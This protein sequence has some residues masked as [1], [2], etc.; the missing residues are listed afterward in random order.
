MRRTPASNAERKAIADQHPV[1]EPRETQ[2][3]VDEDSELVDLVSA[4]LV[5]PRLHTD[6]RM[7]LCQEI[8][9][10]LRTTHED[11][12]GPA[13]SDVYPRVPGVHGNRVP[14]LLRA[15]LVDPNL[16]TDLRMRLYR[17]IPEMVAAATTNHRSIAHPHRAN[18]SL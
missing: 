12:Y 14:S 5:D 16:H 15:V 2:E 17:A 18:E 13:G 11:L 1:N 4:V 7:R 10:L 3:S 8:T 9:A 6:L